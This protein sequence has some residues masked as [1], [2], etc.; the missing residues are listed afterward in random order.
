MRFQGRITEWKNDRDFGFITPN[1]GGARVF[2]HFRSMRGGERRPKGNEL[3]TYAIAPAGDKGP[4]AEDV[5]MVERPVGGTRNARVRHDRSNGLGGLVSGAIS[6]ALLIA[7]VAYGWNRYDVSK[8]AIARSTVSD[9]QR[10][11]VPGTPA[12]NAQPVIETPPA[13]VAVPAPA[14]QSPQYVLD[15]TPPATASSRFKC[16]G[17]THC[18][19]MKSCEE[20][21]FYLKNC[22]GTQ[23]DGDGDGIPCEKQWC[24]AGR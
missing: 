15:T 12:V 11:A 10:E 16:E 17:K 22:P 20:A 6:V 7:I 14:Q 19:Q 3:V 13:F 18:S 1:G 9:V 24:R 2:I 8:R 23:M 4:R 21:T 5:F